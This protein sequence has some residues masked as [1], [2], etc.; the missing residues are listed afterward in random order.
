MD[1]HDRS[2]IEQSGNNEEQLSPNSNPC[3]ICLGPIKCEAYL[4]QCFHNFCYNCILQ[5]INVVSRKCMPRPSSVKCPLCKAD[6][7]SVIH[8]YNR[9]SFQRHYIN[10]DCIFL[11]EAHKYRSQC[12]STET[13]TLGDK[14]DVLRF[15]K[16]RKYLHPNR[17]L[18]DWL[19]R[20]LQALTLE[21]DVEVIVHHIV[22]SIDIFRNRQKH[23]VGAVDVKEQFISLISEAARPFIAGRTERFVN[24][25]ELFLA[26]GLTIDAFDKVYMQQLSCVPEETVE[27]EASEHP[28]HDRHL[29]VFDN[30]SE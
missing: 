4:D 15:W 11:S 1:R 10:E 30:D 27:G 18:H 26:S 3:P 22:G 2:L 19:R 6:N 16:L 25:L 9:G 20:E 12:Y 13:G 28:H 21:E 29:Y 8:G 7:F 14:F 17:W 5:W 24:E 23:S